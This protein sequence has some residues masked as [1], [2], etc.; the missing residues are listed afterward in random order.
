MRACIRT[1]FQASGFV[2]LI[3]GIWMQFQLHKYIDMASFISNTVPAIFVSLGSSI[4]IMA[5][6]AC[7]CAAKEKVSLLYIV[8][9]IL[10]DRGPPISI[11]SQWAI[12]IESVESGAL[13][14]Q[15]ENMLTQP[16]NILTLAWLSF[17][18]Y[19]F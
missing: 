6:L 12:C 19:V 18:I 2:L 3:I 14:I 11:D 7:C 5:A 17:Q 8:S 4:L 1:F 10:R 16:R 9:T 15:S 13:K